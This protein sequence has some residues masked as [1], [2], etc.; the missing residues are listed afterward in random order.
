V[1]AR[2]EAL[3]KDIDRLFG[4]TATTRNRFR[5][6]WLAPCRHA[7]RK[8]NSYVL[9]VDLRGGSKVWRSLRP[10]CETI[11]GKRRRGPGARTPQGYSRRADNREVPALAQPSG[12]VDNQNI[13]GEGRQRCAAKSHPKWRR[14]SASE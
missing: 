9:H 14:C 7:K 4:A 8:R 11:R 13:Q 3:Q 5:A 10:W 2:Q 1:G 6:L 12:F